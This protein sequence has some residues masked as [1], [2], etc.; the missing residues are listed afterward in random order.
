MTKTTTTLVLTL[1][2]GLL[3]AGCS[4]GEETM[5]MGAMSAQV[6][7]AAGAADEAGPEADGAPNEGDRFDAVGT[8]PFVMV[9]H[10]PRSTF[11]ADVDTASYDIFRRDIGF[12]SL[13]RPESVRLEEFVNY[14]PYAYPAPAH[15]ATAPF[16]IQVGAAP[17]PVAAGRTILSIGIKGKEPPP[18]ERKAANLVFLVDV[19]GSMNSGS[20]LGLVQKVLTESLVVLEPTDRVAIVTYAGN[21]AVRLASTPVSDRDRIV[22]V[23]D[24]LRAGG[25]T[26]GAGGIQ[27]AY[28]QAEA[29]FI[30]AGINHVVLCTD[31]DFN[32]GVSSTQGLLDLIREKRQTGV[33]FTALG[34]GAG[35]LNDAMLEAVSNAGNGMYGVIATDDQAIDYVHDRL[36]SNLTLIAK[37][38]KI[39]VWFN[40]AQVLAYRLLGYENRAIADAD[41]RNDVVDA[42]EVGAGHTVT[43]LY[44]LILP[45]EAIPQVEA[46]PE[47]E[48]GE[49][50]DG[51]LEMGLDE[52][53]RVMVR[54]KDVDATEADP[55]REVQQALE[56]SDVQDHL[57]GL[58]EDF[59]WASAVAAFAEILK[60]SPYADA[61]A[62]PVIAE[63][64]ESLAGDDPDRIEFR[65]LFRQ[66][67]ELL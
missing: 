5:G 34:F 49:A 36:L 56:P 65:A 50:F 29:N 19:S 28:E 33:T 23:L 55:A 17:S 14:F 11:A 22:G 47:I 9:S 37:D 20:K 30:E 40:P 54:Y 45:E 21:T 1:S 12:G 62:L 35:N 32:V 18:T 41:F 57:D 53:V 4:A 24:S 25:S 2:T 66:A 42:G 7:R 64:I 26:N 8:N 46:A 67:R 6:P 39:Q 43:A 61:E 63:I 38:M 15:D 27:L 52:L 44:E 31:G 60:T 13:P 59:Q 3:L 16:S 51:E 48:D 58:S 10:D